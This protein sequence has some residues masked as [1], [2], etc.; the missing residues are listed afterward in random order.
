MDVETLLEGTMK[1]RSLLTAGLA[2]AL[3]AGIAC[4]AAAPGQ[5]RASYKVEMDT[6]FG[7]TPGTL[8]LYPHKILFEALDRSQS[9]EWPYTEIRYLGWKGPG[10]IELKSRERDAKWLGKKKTYTFLIPDGSFTEE[11][12]N[13]VNERI[14][15]ALAGEDLGGF[16]A[17]PEEIQ[18]TAIQWPVVRKAEHLHS[19]GSCH[20]TL[21][22]GPDNITYRPQDSD[23]EVQLSYMDIKAVDRKS[24]FNLRLTTYKKSAKKM[25]MSQDIEFNF[26]SE[27]LDDKV[28]QYIVG[29]VASTQTGEE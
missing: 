11:Q 19:F 23:H 26:L 25:W 9:R 27:G 17:N 10:K 8:L 15:K 6:T 3:L 2:L 5:P 20:G 4:P 29:K 7:S 18:A 13:W 28:Y 21:V 12:A 14:Q 22:I 16:A 1:I 24:P